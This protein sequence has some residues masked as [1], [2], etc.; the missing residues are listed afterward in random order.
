M[1]L[2]EYRKKRSFGETPEPAGKKKETATSRF[3][4]QKHDASHLHY[5]FRAEMDGVLRS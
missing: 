5:D 3:V 1:S 2:E 4:V